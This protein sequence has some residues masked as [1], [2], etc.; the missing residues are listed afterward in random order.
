MEPVINTERSVC[1]DSCD[2][3]NILLL[4]AKSIKN[5]TIYG[6]VLLKFNILKMSVFSFFT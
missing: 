4:K 3:N 1:K 2:E 6:T 5:V